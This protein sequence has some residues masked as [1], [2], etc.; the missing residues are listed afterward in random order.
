MLLTVLWDS[1]FLSCYARKCSALHA[2]D[3]GAWGLTNAT[4]YTI[5]AHSV[6]LERCSLAARSLL[7][8]ELFL[9]EGILGAVCVCAL[10]SAEGLCPLAWTRLKHNR[11]LI[12]VTHVLIMALVHD[13]ETVGCIHAR[14]FYTL[15]VVSTMNSNQ[16]LCGACNKAGS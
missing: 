10:G 6:V 15:T 9:S 8:L 7:V 12:L 13:A 4:C 1:M 16:H 3:S 11:P 2:C 5:A 14:G